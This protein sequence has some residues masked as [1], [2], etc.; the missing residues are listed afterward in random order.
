MA[1]YTP[2]YSTFVNNLEEVT[3][4]YK[5]AIEQAGEMGRSNDSVAV[6]GALCRSA[7][8]LL[9]SHIEGYIENLADLI[10]CR[11]VEKRIR[12]SKLSPRFLYYLSKDLLDNI[13]DTENPDSISEK[14][15]EFF[16]RDNYIWSDSDFF[17]EDLRI[18]L[19]VSGFSNPKFKRIKLFFARFG[20]KEYS[21][22][23][24][25]HLK[26]N[27]LPCTNMVDNVVDQRNKIA[28]GDVTSTS[29]PKDLVDMLKLIHL[30]CHST[31]VVIG[32]W[33][34]ELGCPIR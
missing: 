11:I 26:S 24:G 22:D 15:K 16:S 3:A 29:T 28:H 20:Y 32:D 19:F 27:F 33:F 17:S 13:C 8:V 6:R 31:D 21:Q 10:L 14:V 7:I 2:A 30:F 5:L 1:R 9:S 4:L 12:K 18:E 34:S 25:E 23:L